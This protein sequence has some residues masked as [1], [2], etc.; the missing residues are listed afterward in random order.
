MPRTGS[1]SGE[2]DDSGDE[3]RG[4]V[5]DEDGDG[6]EDADADA[7]VDAEVDDAEVDAEVDGGDVNEGSGG[8]HN[9]LSDYNPLHASQEEWNGVQDHGSFHDYSHGSGHEL[10]VRQN[11]DDNASVSDSCPSEY[12]SRQVFRESPSPG[13]EDMKAGF[14][15]HVDEEG[16]IAY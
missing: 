8:D 5:T 7:E 1:G 13:N 6:G 11:E 2:Y 3:E 12:P 16:D 15:I 4:S 10:G 14:R 9:A